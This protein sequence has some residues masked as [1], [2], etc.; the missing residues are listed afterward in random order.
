[1]T[2]VSV[3]LCIAIQSYID[4]GETVLTEQSANAGIIAQIQI[5]AWLFIYQSSFISQLL[6][7]LYSMVT[8]FILYGVTLQPSHI[9]IPW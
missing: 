2:D 1:M 6:D 4:L 5:V 8:I 9:S 3:T 7:L